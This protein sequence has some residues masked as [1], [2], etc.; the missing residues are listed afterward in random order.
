MTASDNTRPMW[1][2][3]TLSFNLSNQRHSTQTVVLSDNTLT[4][5]TSPLSTDAREVKRSKQAVGQTVALPGLR[6]SHTNNLSIGIKT[7][8]CARYERYLVNALSNLH[9]YHILLFKKQQ[10]TKLLRQHSSLERQL[11]RTQRY[12]RFVFRGES[13]FPKLI[14]PPSDQAFHKTRGKVGV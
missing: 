12:S 4:K 9:N 8:N 10:V 5:S 13:F 2:H 7:S 11:R 3:I 1:S 14:F 6:T